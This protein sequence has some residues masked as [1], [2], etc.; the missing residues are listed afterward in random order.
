MSRTNPAND[1]CRQLADQIRARQKAANNVREA[2]LVVSFGEESLRTCPTSYAVK[3]ALAY[4]IYKAEIQLPVKANEVD[5]DKLTAAVERIRECMSHGLYHPTSAF[6]PAL[7]DVVRA[8]L[9][10]REPAARQ[11]A[12]H[13]VTSVDIN[14]VSRIRDGDYPSHA[15]RIFGPAAQALDANPQYREELIAICRLALQPGVVAKAADVGWITF[16]L[17]RAIEE[18]APDEALALLDGL[19]SDARE[20]GMMT[21]YVRLLRRAD[22]DEDALAVARIFLKNLDFGK[23]EFAH[24]VMVDLMELLPD[25]LVRTSLV[26][27]LQHVGLSKRARGIDPRV[28]AAAQALGLPEPETQPDAKL[29]MMLSDLKSDL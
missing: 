16:R 20:Y 8:L 13:L 2:R 19:T 3:S 6:I 1:P 27:F 14:Q 22:R 18:H 7:A 23:L 25:G 15:E 4:A 11:K 17:A 5:V 21:L 10:S 28:A 12:I 24:P 26:V 9:R 29:V